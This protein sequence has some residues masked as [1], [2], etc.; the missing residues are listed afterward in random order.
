[1]VWGWGGKAAGRGGGERGLVSFGRWEV[2]P[3]LKRSRVTATT[4][5]SGSPFQ[6]GIVLGK[7]DI[8]LYCV[9]QEGM[10]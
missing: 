1:M 8:R 2:S 9:L 4:S 7:H 5:S 10:S 3:V 6:S